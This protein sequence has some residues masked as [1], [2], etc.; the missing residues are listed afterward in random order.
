MAQYIIGL[1]HQDAVQTGWK[2]RL[3]AHPNPNARTEGPE[4]RGTQ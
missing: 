4:P 1:T 2:P 3:R